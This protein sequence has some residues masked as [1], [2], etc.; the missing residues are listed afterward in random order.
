MADKTDL[1]F[2]KDRPILLLTIMAGFLSSLSVFITFFRLRS[3]DFKV[4]AQYIP[5]DGSVIQTASWYSLYSLALFA[6]LGAAAVIF[7]AYRL[8][9]ANRLFAGGLLV[10]HIVLAVFGLLVTNALLSLVAGV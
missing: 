3:H 7:L 1:S 2:T 8:H 9:K 4:P 10:A 6:A 5:Q